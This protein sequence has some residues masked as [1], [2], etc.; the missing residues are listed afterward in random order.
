MSANSTKSS[1]KRC[2]AKSTTCC[3]RSLF[4]DFG[5]FKLQ[6]FV[7]DK[8]SGRFNPGSRL[9][10]R[11][12]RIGAIN[13]TC[14][15]IFQIFRLVLTSHESIPELGFD[16]IWLFGYSAAVSHAWQS[17]E[18]SDSLCNFVSA[19]LVYSEEFPGK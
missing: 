19:F 9:R 2:S 1:E 13:L 3:V 5:R 4:Q 7:F 8:A 6:P 17:L 18:D 12:V 15:M 11:L 10:E 14:Y 16:F